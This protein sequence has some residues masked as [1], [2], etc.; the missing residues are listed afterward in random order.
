M[1]LL[2]VYVV[3]TRVLLRLA[4]NRGIG[5][6]N[7]V[8]TIGTNH[9]FCAGLKSEHEVQKYLTHV[10]LHFGHFCM[11]CPS[12]NYFDARYLYLHFVFAERI[13]EVTINS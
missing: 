2:Y 6:T 3:A 4:A 13:F 9:N 12:G 11:A 1:N 5:R 7:Y 8:L 10:I